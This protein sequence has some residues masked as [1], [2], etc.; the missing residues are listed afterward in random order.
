MAKSR[1]PTVYVS[2]TAK[3]KIL[4]EVERWAR[5][6]LM[7]EGVPYEAIAYPLS[8]LIGRGE[9]LSMPSPLETLSV[10]ALSAIV[11]VD[12]AIPPDD[13]KSFSAYNCHF[14]APDLD[15]F[16]RMFNAQIAESVNKHPRLSVFS[17]LHSH[18]F[19]G[20][21]F[22]SSGDLAKNVFHPG[23]VR[24]RQR[25]GMAEMLLHVVYPRRPVRE[26]V[27]VTG[28]SHWETTDFSL[29]TKSEAQEARRR[30]RVADA[31]VMLHPSDQG[32]WGLATFAVSGSGQMVRLPGPVFVPDNSP[33]V[34]LALSSPYWR[35]PR[36]VAWD[37]KQKE[38]LRQAGFNPS[39]GFLGSA[40]RRFIVSPGGPFDV[41]FCIPPDFPQR[42]LRVLRII[43]A[44]RNLFKV[45]PVPRRIREA[46][47]LS[48][49]DLVRLARYYGP[50][51]QGK[52]KKREGRGGKQG[53]SLAQKP[54]KSFPGRA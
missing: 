30:N 25:L 6:G 19:E 41:V 50:S 24:W 14:Q 42:P 23:A 26:I 38:A 31:G 17:K 9:R 7:R 40:W 10:S 8:A 22:L 48:E 2:Q 53:E 28:N 18:P 35:T 47:R 43:D 33:L 34:S 3:Q 12:A 1:L 29:E 51:N 27:K 49:I 44:S 20:G 13:V 36:G 11:L 15:L 21:D 5:E 52:G 46:K 45:L 54:Q 39:R 4:A 16:Q 32:P 37:N